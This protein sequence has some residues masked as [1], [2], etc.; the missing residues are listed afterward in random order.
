MKKVLALGL[1]VA[2]AGCADLNH[3]YAFR[4]E[5]DHRVDDI[6]ALRQT[7]RQQQLDHSYDVIRAK[8]T[9]SEEYDKHGS[10]CGGRIS[11]ATPSPEEQAALRRW[12]AQRAEFLVQ[13]TALAQPVPDMPDRL[14][15]MSENFDR[16]KFEEEAKV[17]MKLD[18]L[19]QGR[20]TYCQFAEANKAI[21]VEANKIAQGFR[22]Q[23][24]E[25]A[26]LDANRRLGYP[27]VT[28]VYT[29]P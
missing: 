21:N 4:Q 24:R 11:N 15:S 23:L 8:L 12:T 10:P 25:E 3:D 27:P 13:L 26:L 20:I 6:T 16:M 7:Y 28:L 5:N 14:K 17:T 22:N 18:D 2:L 29:M 1:A 19:S 9:L